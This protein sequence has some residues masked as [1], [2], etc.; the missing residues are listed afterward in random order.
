MFI[1]ISGK[2]YKNV[3]VTNATMALYPY[4]QEIKTT[5][6]IKTGIN[7]QLLNIIAARLDPGSRGHK[8]KLVATGT[9]PAKIIA[10]GR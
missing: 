8:M 2:S 3:I 1:K 7:D 4:C 6:T 9:K 10:T 5:G